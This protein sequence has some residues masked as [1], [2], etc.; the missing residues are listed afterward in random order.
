MLWLSYIIIWND[1]RRINDAPATD[2]GDDYDDYD[3]SKNTTTTNN[4]N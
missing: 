1:S 4:N 3:G 2:D